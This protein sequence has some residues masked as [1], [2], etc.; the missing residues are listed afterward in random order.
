MDIYSTA[1]L[2]RT[3]NRLDMQPPL[4][5]RST[6]WRTVQTSENERIYFDVTKMIP[7]IAPFVAAHLPGKLV[8]EA[9]YDTYDFKP[10]Y[11]KPKRRLDPKGSIKRQPG[12]AIGGSLSPAERQTRR[13]NAGV[14][15][16]ALL[17]ERRE[18]V[19]ISEFLRTGKITVSGDGF[20][21]VV[22]DLKRDATLTVTLLANDRWSVVHADSNPL[23]DLETMSGTSQGLGAG[24][25]PVIV[26]E[27]KAWDLFIA[28]LKERAELPPLFQYD[29]SSQSRIELAPGLG[30]KVQFKGQIG[31]Y[32]FW[33]YQ[34]VY[35][36]DA[37]ASQKIM[38]DYTV[39][40]LGPTNLEGTRCYGVIEDEESGLV[41]EEL[42]LK[43]WLDKDPGNRWLLGQSAPLPVA[44]RPNASWCLKV[45]G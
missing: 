2:T 29:R 12:E 32:E 41:A 30:E 33:T 40:G 4:F 9:G 28:R 19:M 38:P 8:E 31:N 3:I 42:F 13:L 15:E 23:N 34:D 37:G 16:M 22:V 1:V 24:V 17:L 43:T 26:M 27:P 35:L 36:D 6:F 25:T 14:Q 45:N 44:Y 11:V 20:P 10:A 5:Y 7:R 39:I 21:T 18:E